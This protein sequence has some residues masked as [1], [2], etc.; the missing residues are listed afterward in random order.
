MVSVLLLLAGAVLGGVITVLLSRVSPQLI[1]HQDIHWSPASKVY[2]IRLRNGGHVFARKRAGSAS[3]HQRRAVARWGHVIDMR[4]T[5]TLVIPDGK[6]RRRL[7]V[8]VLNGE[9]GHLQPGDTRF[10]VLDIGQLSEA[11][12]NLVDK[13]AQARN[14]IVDRAAPDL[15]QLLT[16]WD[17]CYIV[18]EAVGNDAW[19]AARRCWEWRY[20]LTRSGADLRSGP[21][22]AGAEADAAPCDADPCG[23]SPPRETPAPASA[24]A[25]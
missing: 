8:P 13:A 16:D 23:K 24:P 18:V 21:F 15:L 1:F 14:K 22:P 19:S 4:T 10:L 3:A 11:A 6:N 7:D 5:V 2:R 17:D 12:R 25:P 9:F 20:N